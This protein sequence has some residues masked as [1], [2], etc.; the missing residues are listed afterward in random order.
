MSV[1]SFWLR[2]IGAS[3]PWARTAEVS[4]STISDASSR[5]AALMIV[6]FSRSSSPMRPIS[7]ESEMAA[8][9]PS[10]SA[11]ISAAR[12]SRSWLTGLNTDE[13]ATERIPCDFMSS[14]CARISSGSRGEIGRPSNS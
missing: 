10:T 5:S 2:K 13:I 6:A 14:A 1:P 11:T 7:W 12:T 3:M 4:P 8:S 9:A